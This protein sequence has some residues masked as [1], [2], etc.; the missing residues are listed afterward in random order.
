MLNGTIGANGEKIIVFYTFKDMREFNNF[1]EATESIIHGSVLQSTLFVVFVEEEAQKSNLPEGVRF[2]YISGSD[3]NFL[4]QLKDKE[5][6]S[7]LKNHFD[8]LLVFDS[9]DEK[10]VKMINKT[11]ATQRI[12]SSLTEGLNF[13]IRLNSDSIKIEQIASFAKDTL[14]KIQR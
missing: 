2:K 12:I 3:F 1:K 4:K 9:I 14:E 7:L 5:L 11:K 13:D 10:Y 8:I 6:R